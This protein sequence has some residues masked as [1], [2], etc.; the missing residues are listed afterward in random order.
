MEKFQPGKKGKKV[1]NYRTHSGEQTGD[2]Y[3]RPIDTQ[4]PDGPGMRILSRYSVTV[5]N[6]VK[7]VGLE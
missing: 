7:A 1:K 5:G 3:I 6:L 4:S 2:S